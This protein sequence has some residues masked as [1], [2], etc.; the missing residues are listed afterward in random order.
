MARVWEAIGGFTTDKSD[1]YEVAFPK[2]LVEKLEVKRN[3]V[4]LG[5]LRFSL[6]PPH[7]HLAHSVIISLL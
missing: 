6:M 2:S 5:T 4:K 1:A 3:R 7:M